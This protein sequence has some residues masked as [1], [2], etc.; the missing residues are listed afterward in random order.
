MVEVACAIIMKGDKVLLTQRSESMEHPLKWEFPG[1]KLKPGESP[2]R[3]IKREIN[4]ELHAQ[5]KVDQLLR[6]VLFDYGKGIFKLI[7]FVCSLRPEDEIT[8]EQH[9]AYTWIEKHELE[10]YDILAADI[11]VIKALNGQW[12]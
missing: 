3:C 11:E 1:G 9:K 8:L 4:E 7:P 10:K 6:S 12:K 2:E 5:I